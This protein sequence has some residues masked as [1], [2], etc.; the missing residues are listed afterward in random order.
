MRREIPYLSVLAAAAPLAVSAPPHHATE[1]RVA[2][3]SGSYAVVA[4]GCEGNVISKYRVDHDNVALD[5]SHKFPWP[6]RVGGRA[7]IVQIEHGGDPTRY[8][9][10]FVS[11]DWPGFSIGAGWARGNRRFPDDEAG[12]FDHTASGHLRVGTPKF[13][14]S[15]SHFEGVPL[16]AD[17]YLEAGFGKG[18]RKT[19]VWV[20]VAGLP[21][22]K[23]GFVTKVDFNVAGGL[24]LNGTGRLGSS[25]GI[26]ENSFALGLSYRWSR[27]ST[28]PQAD[29]SDSPP[30]GPAT[31][32]SAR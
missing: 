24:S 18:W 16:L 28:R 19:Q 23:A 9:N 11:L 27:D 1:I 7:G 4:R 26:P 29:G 8:V 25:E 5:L 31:A 17:G 32:D 2:A 30:G 13:Y 10:P 21:T 22:D 15:A 14:F 20:G 6:V 3:G 12:S